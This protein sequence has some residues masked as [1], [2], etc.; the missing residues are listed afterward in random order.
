MKQRRRRRNY[1]CSQFSDFVKHDVVT[2][3]TSQLQRSVALMIAQIRI[4]RLNRIVQGETEE[5]STLSHHKDVQ[6][7][8][9][10]SVGQVRIGTGHQQLV[11]QFAILFAGRPTV[12]KFALIPAMICKCN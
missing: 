11:V 10:F 2:K 5:A 6:H 3:R 1:L 12:R 9:A 4:G 8:V 7:G